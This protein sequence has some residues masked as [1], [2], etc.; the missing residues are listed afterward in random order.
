M[1]RDHHQVCEHDY[2]KGSMGE[3]ESCKTYESL[4]SPRARI[5]YRKLPPRVSYVVS[6]DRMRPGGSKKKNK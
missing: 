1:Q 3:D 4:T 6:R 5:P 2:R